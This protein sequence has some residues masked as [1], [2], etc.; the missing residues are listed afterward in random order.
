MK[1]LFSLFF[2]PPAGLIQ[3]SF[4]A[5]ARFRVR[6]LGLLAAGLLIS[7][8][9]F[10]HLAYAKAQS[11]TKNNPA[12]RTNAQS[13]L[14]DAFSGMDKAFSQM[15]T[16]F[17]PEDTYYLGRTVAANILT[18]YKP[19]T[20][21]PELTRYLNKICQTILINSPGF[22]LYNGCHVNI[23]DSPD[24]NAFASPGGHIFITRGFVEAAASEDML[25]A[26][27]AHEMA[28]I[29]LKHGINMIS[30]MRLNE[31]MAAAANRAAELTG[32]SQAARRAMEFRNSITTMMDIMVKNGY[33]QGQE[34]EADHKALELLTAAGYDPE[35]LLQVL[36]ILHG[37]QGSHP[38]GL[39]MTHPS[40][41]DRF[42]NAERWI[43]NYR[44]E[45]TR[46]YREPRFRNR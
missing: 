22:E 32:N 4:A 26:I 34:F 43:E 8:F 36:I 25:A 29:L 12:P 39:Y 1:K 30:S 44:I 19:Y 5:T 9:L 38:G 41:V 21:N 6:A 3:R 11:Q 28:H 35:A 20:G 18:I 40:P 31:E 13:F 27:I 46:S 24:Y 45:D 33:S 37:I 10:P 14:N 17:T 2:I 42:I 16:E 23:L 7:S 15:D